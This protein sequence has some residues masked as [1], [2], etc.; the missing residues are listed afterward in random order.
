MSITVRQVTLDD[1]EGITLVL[2]PIV[3]EGKYTILDTTFT[4]EEEKEFIA[5]FPERGVFSVAVSED[6]QVLGFQNV[7]PFADYTKAFDH[8]GIIATYVSSEA[9]GKGISKL[10]FAETFKIA[11]Q[12]GYRKLFAYVLGDND[13]A[14]AAY[15]KQGFGII[16]VAKEQAKMGER[17]V[18][19]TLIEKML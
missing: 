10:L 17:Y 2:N 19:E 4:P 18:D 1:A 5:N 6:G 14:L 15:T 7:E 9:R 11:Q 3:T 16:G 13:R 8:V 12:K